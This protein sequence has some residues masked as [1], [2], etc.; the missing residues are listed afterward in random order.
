MSPDPRQGP[1]N[2]QAPLDSVAPA[3]QPPFRFPRIL[4]LGTPVEHPNRA[5]PRPSRPVSKASPALLRRI[6][7]NHEVVVGFIESVG[8]ALNLTPLS[9]VHGRCC[10]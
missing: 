6:P 3:S 10:V 5:R 2:P 8:E 1:P 7:Q 4:L 9:E